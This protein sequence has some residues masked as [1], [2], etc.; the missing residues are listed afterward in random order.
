MTPMSQQQRGVTMIEILVAIVVM[1]LGLGGIMAMDAFSVRKSHEA[2]LRTQAVL[3]AQEMADR[4]HA[5]RLG[6][7]NGDYVMAALVDT[8][9]GTDCIL[10]SNTSTTCSTAQIAAW[11]KYEWSQ[12]MRN[13]LPSGDASISLNNGVYTITV[14]WL[15]EGMNAT[16]QTSAAKSFDFEYQPLSMN[17]L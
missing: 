10:P 2:F 15:E 9:P 8:A 7:D 11:D 16:G 4:M 5:N 1:A 17:E 12:S 13:L 14:T 6:V 3:Q